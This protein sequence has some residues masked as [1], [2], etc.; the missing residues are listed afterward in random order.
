MD[1]A[2]LI[3]K[4]QQRTLERGKMKHQ[5]APPFNRNQQPKADTL[6]Q[7][8]NYNL[9]RIR[10][11]R[12]YRKANNLCYACG[13]KYEP[14][15][16]EVCSKRQKPQ[17]NALAINDLDKEEITEDML[18]QLAIEDTLTQDFCQ[19]SLN[20]LSSKDTDNSIKLK[21]LVNSKI[22]LI[23]LDSGSSHSFINSDFVSVAQL[24]T[25]PIPPKKVKLPNG[26]WLTATAQ[27]KDLQWY[28]Q[29]HTLSSDMIVLD[30]GPY[31]AILG[32][33]WLKLHSPMECDWNLKTLKF[34]L[35]GQQVKIQGLLN[36][37]LQAT[38]ISATQ[39]VHA[40]QGNDTW[41]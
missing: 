5:R 32:Y 27:V 33:D 4:I 34:C 13:E 30:M 7:Q 8:T 37:P 15:H 41:A 17:V 22:M 19:L 31:D 29:G 12:D 9:Q 23:L 14:G 1:R 39:V 20:A 36:P 10:Q 18:N 2:A 40:A 28:I 35:H 6:V 16:Q 25:V 24:P 3:A 38:P 21:A 26:Q 11:L